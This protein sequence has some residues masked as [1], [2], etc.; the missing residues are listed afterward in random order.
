MRYGAFTLFI[1]IL[2]SGFSNV[3]AEEETF[4]SQGLELDWEYDFGKTFIS[5]KPLIANETLF[6][7]TSTSTSNSA[8][9]YAFDLNGEL[10]WSKM[11]SNSIFNDMSPI[12]YVEQGQGDCGAWPDMLLVGWSDGTVDALHPGTGSVFWHKE[13]EVVT[14]GITGSML[15][16]SDELIV[17]TRNGLINFCLSNGSTNFE[18]QTGLGWRNG[19]SKAGQN[20]F[21]GDEAGILWKVSKEGDYSSKFL[22]IGKI[23]HAPLVIGDM[24]LVHGQG[25]TGSKVALVNPVD[26]SIEVISNSGPSPGIPILFKSIIITID[27]SYINTFDCSTSCQFLDQYPFTSNGESSLVF[28]E[29]FMLPRNTVE[30]GWGIFSIN[31]SGGLRLSELPTSEYDWYGTAG[32]EYQIIAGREILA[33]GNDNGNLQVFSSKN[34]NEPEQDLFESD[35]ISQIGTFILFILVTTSGIQFLRENYRSSFKYLLIIL[36]ALSTFA[37]NDIVLAWSSYVSEINDDAQSQEALWDES[38]P[39][40][41]L[42]TQIVIFEFANQSLISGGH[43]NAKDA[44]ELTH[45]AAVQLDISVED[46]DTSIGK[47]IESFNGVRG[48]GWIFYVD[49]SEAMISSEYAEINS[50]SIVHWKII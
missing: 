3:S 12:T 43:V 44:L 21:L 32:P 24:L 36:V 47:Y 29:M 19:V 1:L 22:D 4:A 31:S 35:Y 17:P 48:E 26:F 20:Y 8:G 28:N 37:F 25:V 6:V 9:I 7:R 46:S 33:I 5:T 42:G 11:N 13:T 2:L 41:W 16:D 49:G 18:V 50:D 15:V 14:W 23:R 39:E 40:E 10:I 27:S 34:V 45:K 30:G 38:W